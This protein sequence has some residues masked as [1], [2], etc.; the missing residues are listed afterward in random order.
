MTTD[1]LYA[2]LF[3][4]I[5]TGHTIQIADGLSSDVPVVVITVTNRDDLYNLHPV[6]Y[7]KLREADSPQLC[8]ADELRAAVAGLYERY[9]Q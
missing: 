8:L 9:N 1:R 2:E 5:R 4:A 6:P 3:Q 7:T